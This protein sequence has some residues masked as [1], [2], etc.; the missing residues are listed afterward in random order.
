MRAIFSVCLWLSGGNCSGSLEELTE[1]TLLREYSKLIPALTPTIIGA[2]VANIDRDFSRIAGMAWDRKTRSS[3]ALDLY[4]LERLR[5]RVLRCLSLSL[6]TVNKDMGF[7]MQLEYFLFIGSECRAIKTQLSAQWGEEFIGGARFRVPSTCKGA[8]HNA[9]WTAIAEMTGVRMEILSL[10]DIQ[11][12]E[13]FGFSSNMRHIRELC[14]RDKSYTDE[15]QLNEDLHNLVRS[16]KEAVAGVGEIHSWFWNLGL[17]FRWKLRVVGALI[18][19]Q[20]TPEVSL[21]LGRLAELLKVG[22]YNKQQLDKQQGPYFQARAEWL[23]ELFS[24]IEADLLEFAT[25]TRNFELL[26]L[27][28]KGVPGASLKDIRREVFNNEVMPNEDAGTL[29]WEVTWLT[30]ALLSIF[31]V[32]VV[33]MILFLGASYHTFR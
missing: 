4:Q 21:N 28:A 8:I 9:A 3:A 18:Y 32:G 2:R 22:L 5:H 11:L 33:T 13:V 10:G 27:V 26:A 29:L 20:I 30:R 17:I 24:G 16:S 25:N 7:G 12:D 14:P 1:E 6:A 19:Q 15:P 31:A 23:A